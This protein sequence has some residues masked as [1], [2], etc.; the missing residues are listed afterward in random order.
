MNYLLNGLN[1]STEILLQYFVVRDRQ[2]V[3]HRKQRP[4]EI[5]TSLILPKGTYSTGKI[6]G[7]HFDMNAA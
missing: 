4:V 2:I 6:R 5:L 3:T 1:V 7:L